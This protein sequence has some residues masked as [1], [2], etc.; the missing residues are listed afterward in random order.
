MPDLLLWS[1]VFFVSLTAL[2]IS[3]DFFIKASERIGLA[4]GI[5]PF[6]I[7][8]TLVAVGTSLPELITSIVA[9][10]DRSSEIVVGNVVGSNITNMGL[11]LGLVAIL[12]KKIKLQFDVTKVDL[13]LMLGATFLIYVVIKDLKFGLIEAFICLGGMLVYL[14]Y[15]LNLSQKDE[16]GPEN[17]VLPELEVEDEASPFSWRDLVTLIG[18]GLVIYFS[19]KYN[20]VAIEE[21]ANMLDIGKEFIAL[22]VVAL[23]TSLPELVVSIAAIR[24]DN[25]EMAVG[26]VLGSN[27][28]N[29]FAVMGIPR[30]FGQIMIP[31]SI[32]TFSL[33]VLLVLTLLTVFVLQD[34]EV[35]RWEG[36]A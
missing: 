22:T 36:F 4:L 5:P 12:A 7:G 24:T 33:P 19:A 21:L 29:L 28:F 18:S 17:P 32:L 15:V 20:V 13:P 31:E 8:V 35:N 34:R 3:A 9:V 27:I 2:I 6:V 16:A 26:N 30:L 10:T 23:G 1:I 25:A 11:V 14:A